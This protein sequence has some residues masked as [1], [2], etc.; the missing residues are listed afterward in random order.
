MF[1]PGKND[2]YV[3]VNT[4]STPFKFI[5]F[6][7]ASAVIP[8]ANAAVATNTFQVQLTIFKQLFCLSTCGTEYGFGDVQCDDGQRLNQYGR[9]L[10][11]NHALLCRT[12]TV[13]C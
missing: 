1:L 13:F 5:F 8:A 12:G 11:A 6:C 9:H 4:M 2:T 7:L 3:E 10:F